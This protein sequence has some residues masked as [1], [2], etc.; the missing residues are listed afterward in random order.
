MDAMYPDPLWAEVKAVYTAVTGQHAKR[1]WCSWRST[2][3]AFVRSR[4]SQDVVAEGQQIGDDVRPLTPVVTGVMG[5]SIA[6]VVGLATRSFLWAIVA[7]L[8]A[9]VGCIVVGVALMIIL[10]GIRSLVWSAVRLRAAGAVAVTRV[11]APLTVMLG[12]SP[13]V[14]LGASRSHAHTT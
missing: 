14:A 8:I 3:G 13:D 6:L 4:A 12:F 11:V 2:L 9:G 5:L 7:A 10:G 1:H